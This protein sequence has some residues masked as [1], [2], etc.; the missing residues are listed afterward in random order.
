MSWL[1]VG[2]RGTG[3]S[4]FGQRLDCSLRVVDLDAALEA[5]LGVPIRDYFERHGEARFRQEE[6]QELKRQIETQADVILLGAGAVAADSKTPVLWVRRDSDQRLRLFVDRPRLDPELSPEEEHQKRFADRDPRY[7]SWAREILTLREG[8]GSASEQS[9]LEGTLN[10]SGATLS[11]QSW[12]YRHPETL[13]RRGEW[14]LS[15]WEWRDDFDL[16]EPPKSPV[17]LLVSS[18]RKELGSTLKKLLPRAAQWDWDLELGPAPQDATILS[19]HSFSRVP[20]G[21]RK[22]LKWSPEIQSLDELKAGHQW[23]L[24]DPKNRSFLPRDSESGRWKWYRLV[25]KNRMLLNFVREDHSQYLDQP[26]LLEWADAPVKPEGFGAVIGDSVQDSWSPAFHSP[27]FAKRNLAFV[28]VSL[29]RSEWSAS[30]L[31]ELRRI[32]LRAAAVT[33]PFKALA[34]EFVKVPGQINTLISSGKT[35]SGT[36]TDSEALK[37]CS[38]PY[39]GQKI[40]IWGAGTLGQALG[41]LL[42][43][44]VVYSARER[45]RV[46]GS[47]DTNPYDVV[48]W[49]AGFASDTLSDFPLVARSVW[50]LEYKTHSPARQLAQHKGWSYVSGEELFTRQALAQQRFWSSV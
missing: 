34:A 31:D 28:P 38:A 46:S 33:S 50:D 44:S 35:W 25:H 29:R 15:F 30:N 43:G 32:G 47:A 20:K 45:R 48:I 3:K 9:F 42:P 40:A 27:F 11:L 49:A 6:S 37:S 24:E 2:H 39:S 10:L 4:T 12:H 1:V 8:F 17:P 22:H 16:P 21:N 13:R 41:S 23:W 5:R 36:D 26:T 18:R 19:S 7:Q 14:G